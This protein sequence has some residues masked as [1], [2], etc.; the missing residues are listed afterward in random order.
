MVEIREAREE[1]RESAPRL[2]W[3]AFEATEDFEQVRA[4]SWM[5]RWHQPKNRDWAFVAVDDNKVVSNLSFFVTDN[6]VIRGNP[7]MFSGVWAVATEPHY[8]RRGLVRKLF[9][10]SFPRMREEGAVLSILD[11]FYRPFYEKFGYALAERR[12]KHVFKRDQLRYVKGPTD[13]IAHEASTS[14]DIDKAIEVEKSM[15]RFGS[16]FFTSRIIWQEVVQEGNLH[17]LERDSKPVATVGFLFRKPASGHG[18]DVIVMSTRFKT[19]D[20][21]PAVL[22]LV[23]NYIPTAQT[24]TWWL[25]AEVP[26]R[27]FFVS[28]HAETY[29][30]GSMMMRVIDIEKYCSSIRVPSHAT[31]KVT[32]ELKDNQCPWNSGRYTLIPT[33]GRLEALQANTTPDIVLNE[34]QLSEVIS[35][36]SPP[37]LLRAFREIDCTEETAIRLESIFPA[38]TFVSYLRF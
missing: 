38:E 3:R 14:G 5:K 17:I 28:H 6:D 7:V 24:V 19:D 32:I 4:K 11:P 13:I 35:G 21:F 31:E 15:A 34:F 2:L 9:D 1:D 33:N 22:E 27:H 25:D 30:M 18:Y 37:T 23:C 12:A 16:R 10:A 26:L 8:R 20:V 36:I 29:Q